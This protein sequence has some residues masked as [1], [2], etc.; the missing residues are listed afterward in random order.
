MVSLVTLGFLLTRA[1]NPNLV[2]SEFR[3][4]LTIIQ[5][6]SRKSWFYGSPSGGAL[7]WA[8][9]RGDALGGLL[10]GVLPGPLQRRLVPRPGLAWPAGLAG[11]LGLAWLDCGSI[12]VGLASW[13]YWLGLFCHD[14]CHDFRCF[15]V[16]VFFVL[17]I[18][19][20]IGLLA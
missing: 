7:G 14:S 16:F 6:I 12:G 4:V 18:G 17:I 15:L 11:L 2:A 5:E 1:S 10:L 13:A 3:A 8:S 9:P 19:F 20:Y